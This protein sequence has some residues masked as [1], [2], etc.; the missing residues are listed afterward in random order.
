MA[1][2]L[3]IDKLLLNPPRN[4]IT[5]VGIEL[6][7]AWTKVPTGRMEHD[8]SV[9]VGRKAGDPGFAYVGEVVSGPMQPAK[10][11]FWLKKNYPYRVNDTCGLHMHMELESIGKYNILTAPEFQET[12]LEYFDKWAKN[13]KLPKTHPIWTRILGNS[14]FCQKEWWPDEQIRPNRKDYDKE[15][16]G[17]RYTV[18][19][20]C[21]GRHG[22]IECRLLPMFDDV[23][24][25]IRALKLLLD[26]TN[27]SLVALSKGTKNEKVSLQEEIYEED[28]EYMRVVL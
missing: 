5:R 27:C 22:T 1:E 13:E 18:I 16:H 28:I 11:P 8:S 21:F 24:Q 7:G 3:D 14:I 26:I 20:Y 2:P 25:S 10:I 19:C 12:V 6:E 15:R 17:H 23:E 4:R 9:V